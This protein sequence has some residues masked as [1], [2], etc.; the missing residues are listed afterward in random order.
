MNGRRDRVRVRP[1]QEHRLTLHA[2][3]EQLRGAY[4]ALPS[5]AAD[6]AVGRKKERPVRQIRDVTPKATPA[7]WENLG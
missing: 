6:A 4:R 3:D 5:L 2:A 1:G 7:S